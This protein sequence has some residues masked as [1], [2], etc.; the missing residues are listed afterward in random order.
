MALVMDGPALHLSAPCLVSG[1]FARCIKGICGVCLLTTPNLVLLR[2]GLFLPTDRRR[3]SVPPRVPAPVRYVHVGY[4]LPESERAGS[5][6][7]FSIVAFLKCSGGFWAVASGYERF[8]TWNCTPTRVIKEKLDTGKV[9]RDSF[10]CA[11]LGK[12]YQDGWIYSHQRMEWAE[13]STQGPRV[14]N[15]PSLR[16]PLSANTVLVA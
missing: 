13:G 15:S 16:C 12:Y 14:A 3:H 2:S 10:T 6:H 1:E 9:W 5:C 11:P 4:L 8:P 7:F